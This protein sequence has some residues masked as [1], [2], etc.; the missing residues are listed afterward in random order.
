M[1]IFRR[2]ALLALAVHGCGNGATK[3]PAAGTAAASAAGS[4]TAEAGDAAELQARRKKWLDEV[5]GYVAAPDTIPRWR[6]AA[7]RPAIEKLTSDPA[8]LDVD[9]DRDDMDQ[10]MAFFPAVKALSR[11]LTARRAN[12]ENALLMLYMDDVNRAW[13]AAGER[14]L[15]QFPPNDPSQQ[16]RRNGFE[17]MRVAAAMNLTGLLAA[18]DGAS[19]DIRTRVM[20]RLDAPST[21]AA[22]SRD[23]LQF[24]DATLADEIGRA[25]VARRAVLTKIRETAAKARDAMPAAAPGRIYEAL[26]H[27]TSLDTQTVVS[28]A[29]R[30][31]VTAGPGALL[32]TVPPA[33]GDEALHQMQWLND[34]ESFEVMCKRGLDE[35]GLITAFVGAGAKEI[36]GPAAGRWLVMTPPGREARMRIVN[37]GANTCVAGAEAPAGRK[38]PAQFEELLASLR[39]P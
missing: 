20:A 32:W 31:A 28:R 13:F 17:T 4:A 26:P 33:A 22:L 16:P 14:K 35:A 24:F 15:A 39:A 37:I 10:A 5:A 7:G 9:I 6:D 36:T 18:I 19:P 30:F 8:W 23:S 2:L 38:T 27:F 11:E 1:H 25:G 21:Y 12:D 3:A 34:G 29:G